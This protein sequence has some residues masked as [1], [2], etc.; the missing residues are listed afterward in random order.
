MPETTEAMGW[1]FSARDA[2]AGNV[3]RSLGSELENLRSKAPAASA[4]LGKVSAAIDVQAVG[5]LRDAVSS[6]MEFFDSSRES[7]KGF[8]K[9]IAEASTLIDEAVFPAEKMRATVMDLTRSYG[10]DT[11][12]QAR[13]L[14]QTI[15]SGVTDSAQATDLLRVANQ[16]AIG[17]S[18]ELEQTVLAL[19]KTMAAYSSQGATATDVSD[20]MFTAVR[21]GQIEMK[22]IA[23]LIGM[24]AGTAKNAGVSYGELM[25]AIATTTTV[26][27]PEQVVSGLSAAF[28]NLAKPAHDARQEAARLGIQFTSS[29]MRAKGFQ[30][31][32]NSITSSARFNA[33]SMTK[34]F[35][36]MEASRVM[37]ELTSGGGKRFNEVMKDM[38]GRTGATAAAFG[39]MASTDWFHGE[40][41]KGLAEV[42]R[43]QVGE[44]IAPISQLA[45]KVQGI[46][47]DMWQSLSPGARTW[48][49]RAAYAVTATLGLAAGIVGL[50]IAF[51]LLASTISGTFLVAAPMLALLAGGALL[52]SGLGSPLQKL[53]ATFK[54]L[55]ALFTGGGTMGVELFQKLREAGVA[56]TVV[57]IW[58]AFQRVGHFFSEMVGSFQSGIAKV[59][60]T[61]DGLARAARTFTDAIGLTSKTTMHDSIS[62]WDAWGSAGWKMGEALTK[63]ADIVAGVLTHAFEGLTGFT[64]QLREDW[65]QLAGD[66]RGAAEALREVGAAVGW[67]RGLLG[68]KKETS[69]WGDLGAAIAWVGTRL[70]SFGPALQ[71]I[72]AAAD[73]ARGVV[74]SLGNLFLLLGEQIVTAMLPPLKLL[75]KGEMAAGW[76]TSMRAAR[77]DLASW[78]V[79]GFT[80]QQAAMEDQAATRLGIA[81]P[82]LAQPS[83][84]A[85][86]MSLDDVLNRPAVA[87]AE[88]Q[89]RLPTQFEQ[90]MA[91]QRGGR[92]PEVIQLNVDGEKMAEVVRN[93]N[94]GAAVDGFASSTPAEEF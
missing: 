42:L 41:R 2:S 48:A 69:E 80:A 11:K 8:G 3:M 87:A 16:L 22:D 65:P 25:G 88:R 9:A 72:R 74:A 23:G 36:S 24:V 19:T 81:R 10:G 85:G 93:R 45:H 60:P 90:F 79:K 59:K 78:S 92:G 86:G 18:A 50:K 26:M 67:V 43:I 30:G 27:K 49:I 33:D 77:A 15:S 73:F 83:M 55:S 63:V 89:D 57:G 54:G 4:A 91:E 66:F 38:V 84:A 61:F 47:V 7:A 28:M 53:T 70:S 31:F 14:Y 52:M 12:S 58:V 56:D 35:G 6:K 44:A 37:L 40:Q 21:L 1:V 62:S 20:A 46:V 29:A 39:K 34:L 71:G 94:R 32:I 75:G 51:G 17:G 82:N 76:L 5:M 13:G 64:K 68:T